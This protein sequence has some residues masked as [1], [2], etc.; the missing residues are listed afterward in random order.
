MGTTA[1]TLIALVSVIAIPGVVGATA[2]F[3]RGMRLLWASLAAAII[4]VVWAVYWVALA[5]P[6]HVKHGILFAG[7]AVIA[8]V[9]A[10]FGRPVE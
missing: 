5:D 1:L 3:R 4:A 9:A 2:G 10:S 7:L 6:R 8:L